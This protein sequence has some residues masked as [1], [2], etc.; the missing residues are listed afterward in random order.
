MVKVYESPSTFIL[1]IVPE[2]ILCGSGGS[3]T[4]S[5]GENNGNWGF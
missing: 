4:E 2:G 1:D 3:S 5:L